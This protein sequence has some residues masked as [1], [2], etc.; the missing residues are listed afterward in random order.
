[1]K[2]TQNDTAITSSGWLIIICEWKRDTHNVV[3]VVVVSVAP[4]K[5]TFDR[6]EIAW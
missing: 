6:P 4:I 3:V 1:M 5:D 2:R